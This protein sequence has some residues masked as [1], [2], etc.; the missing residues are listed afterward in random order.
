MQFKKGINC[1]A[2]L[3]SINALM[4]TDCSDGRRLSDK[5]LADVLSKSF[6]DH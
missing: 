1:A 3:V 2:V 6:G 5:E 4:L